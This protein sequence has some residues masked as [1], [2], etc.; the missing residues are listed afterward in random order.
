ML[1]RIKL[2]LRLNSSHTNNEKKNSFAF[3]K[4]QIKM[5]GTV[6]NKNHLHG[7]VEINGALA[8][9]FSIWNGVDIM[10]K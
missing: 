10:K 9:F 4:K 2:S 3:I 1:L 8:Y 7:R 5:F 6:S